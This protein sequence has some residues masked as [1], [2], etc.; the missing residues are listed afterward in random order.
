MAAATILDSDA[1][2]TEITKLINHPDI[3]FATPEEIRNNASK[4][5]D[6]ILPHSFKILPK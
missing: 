2:K 4:K 6:V 5:G 1:Q 3:L